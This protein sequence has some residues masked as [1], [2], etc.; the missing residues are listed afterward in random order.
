[1]SNVSASIATIVSV[2]ATI[3]FSLTDAA[4]AGQNDAPPIQAVRAS[5]SPAIDGKLEDDCWQQATPISRFLFIN[6]YR[7]ASFPTHGYVCYDDSHLYLASKFEMPKG[8]KPLGKPR[9]HDEYIF[10]DDILEIM[11]DP[12]RSGTNYYQLALNAYGATWDSA[13]RGGGVQNDR[14][15]NGDWKSAVHIADGYWS[16]ELSIPFHNLGI[17]PEMG[18]TWA[19]NFCREMQRPHIE[20]LATAVRGT[21][22][23]ADN[24]NAVEGINVDFSRYLIGISRGIVRLTST[25]DQPKGALHMPVTNRSGK[26]QNIKID[27][28]GPGGLID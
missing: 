24:F 6:S 16:A 12:G 2:F 26:T 11:L 7:P 1:M 23:V 9:P 10:G 28:L 13:R 19:I 21:F 4:V 14:N 18:S 8:V 15:W 17:T 5:T 3:I 22:H 20:Y 27:R 25:G